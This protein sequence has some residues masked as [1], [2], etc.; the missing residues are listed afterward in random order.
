MR[1]PAHVL[2]AVLALLAPVLGASV[3]DGPVLTLAI[4]ALACAA[5]VRVGS[6]TGAL[7]TRTPALAFPDGGDRPPVLATRVTDPVH[8]PLRPRAPGPA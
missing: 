2:V 5:L 8:H 6:R 1:A 7:V 3:L 4:V